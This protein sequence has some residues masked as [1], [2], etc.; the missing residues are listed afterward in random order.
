M[1]KLYIDKN[2]KIAVKFDKKINELI[3]LDNSILNNIYR[4]RVNKILKNQ[5]IAFLSL[6]DQDVFM[7][8][9]KIDE[10]HENDEILV[11][12]KKLAVEDKYAELSTELSL[13]GES[14]IYFI[15]GPKDI[16]FSKKISNNSRENLKKFARENNFSSLLFRS[17]AIFAEEEE[18][19]AEYEKFKELEEHLKAQINL[20]PT[21][22]LLYKKN[23]LES[24]LKNYKEEIICNDME[25]FKA[26]KD[27]FN[28]KYDENFSLAYKKDF[29]EDYASLFAKKIE[30][31]NGGNI[32]IEET[33]ALTSID[34]NASNFQSNKNKEK[35]IFELN[36]A[37]ANEIY[38]QVTLRNISGIIIIDFVNMKSKTNKD[39]LLNHLRDKFKNDYT[40]SKVFG[41][42]RLGL[43]EISRKSLGRQ[44]INKL[45]LYEDNNADNK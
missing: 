18:I 39:K 33:F 43:V 28:I 29:I 34:V 9:R 4:A 2:L 19:I 27:G 23:P 40:S 22:K 1:E 11:Q 42:T 21:P 24:F 8:I 35:F 41:Y 26:L 7:N 44:L 25:I 10:I 30:L 36:L 15:N 16:K 14:I 37:A 5:K 12:V 31:E 32:I 20:R 17:N 45:N 6:E 13:E 3:D 38:R